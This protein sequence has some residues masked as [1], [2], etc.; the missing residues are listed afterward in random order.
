MKRQEQKF[1]DFHAKKNGA[2]VRDAAFLR[3]EAEP[4]FGS[5]VHVK[6]LQGLA[7]HQQFAP[8]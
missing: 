3:N 4:K 6:L 5:I 8:L 1:G 7:H 2:P